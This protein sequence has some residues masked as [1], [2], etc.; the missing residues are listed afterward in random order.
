MTGILG[1][2]N[3]GVSSTFPMPIMEKPHYVEP[4]PPKTT[5]VFNPVNRDF[6]N[7]YS[8]TENVAKNLENIKMN[9][10]ESVKAATVRHIIRMR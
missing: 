5:L 9:P 6:E 10:F 8:V 2:S 7:A 3:Y 1:I 4:T